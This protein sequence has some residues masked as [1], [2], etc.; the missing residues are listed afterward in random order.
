MRKQHKS[1]LEEINLSSEVIDDLGWKI[2]KGAEECLHLSKAHWPNL[3]TIILCTEDIEYL[4]DNKIC[5]E[6]CS[7]LSKAYWPNL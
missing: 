5:T 6:G 4:G 7:N 2:I 1:E 3:K